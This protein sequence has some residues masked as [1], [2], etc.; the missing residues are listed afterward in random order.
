M[1]TKKGI[2]IVLIAVIALLGFL[3]W[4]RNKG[5]ETDSVEVTSAPEPAI[6]NTSKL[7]PSNIPTPEATSTNTSM[8][9]PT[10]TPMPKPTVAST[11]VPTPTTNIPMPEPTEASTPTPEATPTN[12]PTPE[13][14]PANTPTPELTITNTPVPTQVITPEPT[15]TNTP[16]PTSTPSPT[17]SPT[18]TPKPTA[19]PLPSYNPAEHGYTEKVGEWKYGENIM[20]TLWWNGIKW[21]RDGKACVLVFEGTGETWTSQETEAVYDL[22]SAPWIW[23]DSY[24]DSIL[25]AVIG[26]GIT[27]VTSLQLYNVKYITLPNS[28]K[29]IGSYAFG[30]LNVTSVVIPGGVTHIEDHAFYASKLTTVVIPEGVEYIGEGA[31]DRC[32]LTEI[33]LPNSLKYI[34]TAAFGIQYVVNAEKNLVEEV[35]IPAGVETI[36][37]GA[38]IGRYGMKIYLEERSSDAGFEKGWNDGGFDREIE[39]IYNYKR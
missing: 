3:Y 38:F 30:S 16:T 18:I 32:N 23:L 35:V 1:K 26:E 25:E 21:E 20:A 8:P 31:F 22:P 17:K 29:K 5:V 2:G 24:S 19:T 37:F 13:V 6:T 27:G 28:L 12:T 33:N 15:P 39:V 7:T 36:E 34:G 14:T 10:A 9:K 4:H 11:P